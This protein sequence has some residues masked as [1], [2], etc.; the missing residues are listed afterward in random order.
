MEEVLKLLNGIHEPINCYSACNKY[1]Q[2]IIAMIKSVDD[3][4]EERRLD[5]AEEES[6]YRPD[7]NLVCEYQSKKHDLKELKTKQIDIIKRKV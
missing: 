1:K 2:L 6:K 7:Y 3:E 4:I 5:I